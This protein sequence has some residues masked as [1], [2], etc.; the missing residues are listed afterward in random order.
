[1]IMTMY[2]ILHLCYTS[3]R[4]KCGFIANIFFS[5]R[6]EKLTYLK[7]EMYKKTDA[8]NYKHLKERPNSNNCNNY[9]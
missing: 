3:T 7:E 9:I 1:M 5:L 4:N 6:L 8:K 2:C